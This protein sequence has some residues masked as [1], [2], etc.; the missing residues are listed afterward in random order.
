MANTDMLTTNQLAVALLERA[1]L[2][3]GLD[4]IRADVALDLY[5]ALYASLNILPDD[6]PAP[7]EEF[8]EDML[9]VLV[10]LCSGDQSMLTDDAFYAILDAQTAEEAQY[11]CECSD[12]VFFVRYNA[13][14]STHP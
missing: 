2:T 9:M 14:G 5:E 11:Y 3:N 10:H 13:L 7:R 4:I 6:E 8:G 1:Q 12:D